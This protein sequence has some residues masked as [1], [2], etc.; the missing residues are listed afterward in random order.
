[1]LPR[2]EVA[3]IVASIGM[4]QQHLSHHA[5]VALVI[6]TVV[7]AI[8]ASVVVPKLASFIAPKSKM[9]STQ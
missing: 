1:M 8:L 9:K 2:A 3:I 5:M 4:K 7:T 6:M